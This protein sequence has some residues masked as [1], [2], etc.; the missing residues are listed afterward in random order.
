MSDVI[1]FKPC[2]IIKGFY[3]FRHIYTTV[4]EIMNIDVIES[5]CNILDEQKLVRPSNHIKSF[6]D[7]ITFVDDRPGHDK[8]YAIDASKISLELNW[9]PIESFDTGLRKTVM[10]YLN[11]QSWCN[12][13]LNKN[14]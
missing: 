1:T 5:I 9:K 14:T 4:N 7:L 12:I 13:V 10:W 11:N 6:S 8:R 3:F 2:F